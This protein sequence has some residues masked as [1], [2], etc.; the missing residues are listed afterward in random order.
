MTGCAN[1][2]TVSAA[3]EWFL[4]R[5]AENAGELRGQ[6]GRCELVIWVDM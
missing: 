3:H 2:E 1:E 5:E 4:W 6:L